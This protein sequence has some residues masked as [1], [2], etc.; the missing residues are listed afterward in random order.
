LYNIHNEFGIPMKL[1]MLIKMCL[2]E[3]HN[4]VQVGKNIYNMFPIKNV[5]KQGDALSLLLFN[6]AL[7]YAIRWVQVKH[8]GLKLRY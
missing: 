2:N 4:T 1:V 6:F 7:E 8:D 5:W 3:I